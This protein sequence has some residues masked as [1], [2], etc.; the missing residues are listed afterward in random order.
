MDA[1]E[2]VCTFPSPHAAKPHR[3]RRL[4]CNEDDSR[5]CSPKKERNITENR[6]QNRP[7]LSTKRHIYVR[8]KKHIKAVKWKD[9]LSVLHSQYPRPSQSAQKP[10]GRL[11]ISLLWPIFTPHIRKCGRHYAE[12]RS[13]HQS[14][15]FFLILA[16]AETWFNAVGTFL[17]RYCIF[18][19]TD[20]AAAVPEIY[21]WIL[22]PVMARVP[23]GH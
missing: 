20:P 3:Q 10:L 23:R 12:V 17:L 7:F 22:L 1:G 13:L 19:Q 11:I 18:S 2:A 14:P 8:K 15:F 4:L 5:L 9:N 21:C 16:T 6:L